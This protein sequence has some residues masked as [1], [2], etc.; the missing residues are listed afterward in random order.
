MLVQLHQG[1][2]Q[3][4]G[5]LS[6]CPLPTV[7]SSPDSAS[8]PQHIPVPNALVPKTILF[9]FPAGGGTAGYLSYKFSFSNNNNTISFI[10]FIMIAIVFATFFYYRYQVPC[11]LYETIISNGREGKIPEK[12]KLIQPTL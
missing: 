9:P 3:I 10:C 4:T 2:L 7:L 5:M 8:N 11:E 12:E 6:G 1:F